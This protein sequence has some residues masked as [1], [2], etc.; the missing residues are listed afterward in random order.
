MEI[1]RNMKYSDMETEVLCSLTRQ[2]DSMAEEALILRCTQLVRA[3]ARPLFLMGGDQE[4]LMQEGMLGLLKA[5]QDYDPSKGSGFR[6]F[7]ETCVRNRMISAIRS[8][9]G[10]HHIPLND[11]IPIETPFLDGNSTLKT[12]DPEEIYISR[13]SVQEQLELL[14]SRLSGFELQVLELYLS[15]MSISE[16]SEAVHRPRKSVDNAIQRVRRKFDPDGQKK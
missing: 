5:I 16:I 11:S 8:A 1:E 3:C 4:D 12:P 7:A 9:A 2:G 6:T 13:E 14:R 10:K 15:G